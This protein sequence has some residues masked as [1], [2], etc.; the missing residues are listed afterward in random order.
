MIVV[1]CYVS[2]I[3]LSS[4]AITL[5]GKSEL[6]ALLYL[7]SWCLVFYVA[8]PHGVMS[9][10]VIVVFSDHAHL[11]FSYLSNL[12]RFGKRVGYGLSLDF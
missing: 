3:V 9:R 8:L 10:S 7:Y 5:M 11:H 1:H 6:V 2:L 4:F 12:L